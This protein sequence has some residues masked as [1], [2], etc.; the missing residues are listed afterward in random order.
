[1]F[2]ASTRTH[3]EDD[4]VTAG[5]PVVPGTHLDETL[6][7]DW[8]AIKAEERRA[9]AKARKLPRCS[10]CTNPMWLDQ[11]GNHHVCARRTGL[12]DVPERT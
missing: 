11:P 6:K 2:H 9:K 4:V 3:S 10:T 1:M 12:S 8:P 7:L 5:V